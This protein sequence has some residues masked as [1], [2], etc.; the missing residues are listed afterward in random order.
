MRDSVGRVIIVRMKRKEEGIIGH[1]F[2]GMCVVW[3]DRWSVVGVYKQLCDVCGGDG[4]S[5]GGR[6]SM[7]AVALE[8][9]IDKR[10]KGE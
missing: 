3:S 1:D 10:F 8:R 4:S 7:V 2:H 6:L 9:E 5:A